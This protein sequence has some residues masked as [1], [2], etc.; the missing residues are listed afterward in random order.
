MPATSMV[1]VSAL[2]DPRMMVEVEAV[3][4]KPGSGW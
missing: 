4:Y 2:I 3:A 1:Q